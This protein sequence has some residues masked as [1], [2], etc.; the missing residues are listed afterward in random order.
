MDDEANDDTD[1]WALFDEAAVLDE[2][3]RHDEELAVY[4]EVVRRYGEASDPRLREWVGRALIDKG[5]TLSH[6]L[7][8]PHDAF[9][10][11]DEVL[12]RFGDADDVVSSAAV[13]EM[14]LNRAELLDAQDRADHK[15]AVYDEIV[16]RYDRLVAVMLASDDVED[17]APPVAL[18][19]RVAVALH[20]K[21]LLLKAHD[22][23]DRALMAFEEIL[24][25]FGEDPD[26][27]VRQVVAGAHRG[28]AQVLV[29][30]GHIDQAV[31][32][33]DDVVALFDGDEEL[34]LRQQVYETLVRKAITLAEAERPAEAVALD[35]ELTRRYDRLVAQI[36]GE[37]HGGLDG[38]PAA[39]VHEL[40][41]A[42]RL[43][44][45]VALATLGRTDEA[46]AAYD[47][48]VARNHHLAARCDAPLPVAVRRTAAVALLCRA[49][50]LEE[51]EQMDA[52]LA[53]Y[54]AV[55]TRFGDDEDPA[56]RAA[57]DQAREARDDLT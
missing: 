53:A 13:V 54:G 17:A 52:A 9:V 40:A 16:V 21:G 32:G 34:E 56:V 14:L 55:V 31:A 8:R 45:G 19:D 42:A 5:I 43:N 3:G 33:F 29:E 48:V 23:L 7:G 50:A 44:H 49:E 36:Q 41:A 1:A 30:L 18:R 24:V 38:G 27:A 26:P 20:N 11:Y 2:L 12:A 39:R 57:V 46:L 51:R 47:E 4:D 22:Q 15:L 6:D 25:R 37:R 28:R 35:G 10:V